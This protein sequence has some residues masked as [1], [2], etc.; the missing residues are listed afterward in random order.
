VALE[1]QINRAN[2]IADQVKKYDDVSKVLRKVRGNLRGELDNLQLEKRHSLIDPSSLLSQVDSAFD[3]F[4]HE[5]EDLKQQQPDVHDEDKLRDQIDALFEGRVGSHPPSQEW[6]DQL[7]S[8]GNVRY[9]QK[10]PPGYMDIGKAKNDGAETHLFGNLLV[11]SEYGDLIVWKQILEESRTREQLKHLVFVTD[12]EKEDWWWIVRSGGA[13]RLGPRPELAEEIFSEAGIS[14]F[15]IYNSERF[16]YFAERFLDIPVK[17]ESVEQ[18]RDVAESSERERQRQR[19]EVEP[20]PTTF[21]EKA[22]RFLKE[23]HDLAGGDPAQYVDTSEAAERAGITNTAG[24]INSL[25]R[26]LKNE[27]FIDRPYAGFGVVTI[28]PAGIEAVQQ[29]RGPS[30]LA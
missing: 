26:Y 17:Q 20:Y 27:G 5:L 9:E 25:C 16:L 3:Q 6:L 13:K 4:E 7:Y 12:D 11:R 19:L 8:E 10:R 23:I 2:V 28:T 14:R 29:P 24:T 1:Y 21:H 15:Y 18:V 22:N 30:P